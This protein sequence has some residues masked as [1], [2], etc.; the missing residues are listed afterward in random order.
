MKK[1]KQQDAINT[2]IESGKIKLFKDIFDYYD[3]TPVIAYLKTNHDT[4]TGWI[5]NPG[6]IRVEKS[7]QIAEYFSVD[8][9]K[10]LEI[11]YNQTKLEKKNR[12]K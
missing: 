9:M 11:I 4:L 6:M 2:L 3:I 8:G 10:M 12:R 1:G 5:N 7:N